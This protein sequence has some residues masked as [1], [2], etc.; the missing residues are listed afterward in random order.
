M[1]PSVSC[2][3]LTMGCSVGHNVT[4]YIQLFQFPARYFALQL[5]NQVLPMPSVLLKMFA[6]EYG[7]TVQHIS[8][9]PFCR[10]NF[11]DIRFSEPSPR[12]SSWRSW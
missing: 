9:S 1:P 6:M 7:R 3:L 5:D 8:S 12:N 2:R 4:S 11:P 10:L